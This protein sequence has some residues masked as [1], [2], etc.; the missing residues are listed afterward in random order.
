[1]NWIPVRVKIVFGLYAVDQRD[2]PGYRVG[3]CAQPNRRRPCAGRATL[4]ETIAV[5][6]SAFVSRKD[7]VGLDAVLRAVV[8]RNPD[9][10][11]F[12]LRKA[13]GFLITDIGSHDA[14]W[15]NSPIRAPIPPRAFSCRFMREKPMGIAGNPL[16]GP[17]SSRPVR[18]SSIRPTRR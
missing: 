4:A 10:L 13:N 12:G 5:N 16:P 17:E 6:T 2:G 3:L 1:M 11:S 15:R 14:H 7:M 18:D 8:Q 9:I